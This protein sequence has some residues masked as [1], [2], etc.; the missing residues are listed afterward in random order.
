MI[1]KVTE[2]FEKVRGATGLVGGAAVL[3]RNGKA[4]TCYF[5]YSDR[6]S[7]LPHFGKD[8]F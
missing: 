6:E 2:I 5:G 8:L 7:G 3:V 4:E 1:Q